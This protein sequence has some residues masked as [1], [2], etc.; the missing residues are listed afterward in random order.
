MPTRGYRKGISDAKSAAP[1]RMH[2]R[3]P[4]AVHDA[5]IADSASRHRPASEIMRAVLVAHYTGTRVELPHARG[6]SSAAIRELARIGNNLNQLSHQA[7]LMRL[8]L[9]EAEARRALKAVLDAV[10]RL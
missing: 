7:N 4:T 8:P 5:L 3:L 1:K 9:I 6:P 2:T 10:A